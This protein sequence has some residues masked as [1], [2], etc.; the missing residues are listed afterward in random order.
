M[1]DIDKIK[2]EVKS[3]LSYNIGKR[4]NTDL[5]DYTLSILD[6]TYSLGMSN[7]SLIEIK[8]SKESLDRI[9]QVMDNTKDYLKVLVKDIRSEQGDTFSKDLEYTIEELLDAIERW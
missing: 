4:I 5:V 9:S 3:E 2:L 6:S 1:K 8:K 7:G